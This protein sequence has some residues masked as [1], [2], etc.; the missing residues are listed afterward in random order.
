VTH[1]FEKLFK[2]YFCKFF[3]KNFTGKYE[4]K[5]LSVLTEMSIKKKSL[6]ANFTG[7]GMPAPG[8]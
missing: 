6:S 3:N 8:I 2:S 7:N 1:I 4:N 5:I